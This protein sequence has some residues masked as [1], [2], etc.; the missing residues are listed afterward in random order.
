MDGGPGSVPCSFHGIGSVDNEAQALVSPQYA[1]APGISSNATTQGAD[2]SLMPEPPGHATQMAVFRLRQDSRE[3]AAAAPQG[4]SLV[5]WGPGPGGSGWELVWGPACVAAP[6]E[7]LDQAADL[8]AATAAE[9]GGEA[10]GTAGGRAAYGRGSAG[11]RAVAVA[12]AVAVAKNKLGNE[13]AGQ[14]RRAGEGGAL[15]DEESEVAGSGVPAQG[16]AERAD[17]GSGGGAGAGTAAGHA[18][19][20]GTGA[21]PVAPANGGGS[22]GQRFADQEHRAVVTL[23]PPG[24]RGDEG[25]GAERMAVAWILVQG[26][27]QKFG[28]VVQLCMGGFRLWAAALLRLR[29]ACGGRSFGNFPRC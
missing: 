15:G 26:L 18:A 9:G 13:P 2:S 6:K 1:Q 29:R 8:A 11:G 16:D 14:K 12:V 10:C 17:A 21:E 24:A 7:E 25:A 4:S 19:G 28:S 3:P 5:A 22:V 23:Q 27:T 20:L